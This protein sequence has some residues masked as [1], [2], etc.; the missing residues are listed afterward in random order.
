MPNAEDEL[1]LPELNEERIRQNVE[2][3]RNNKILVR[4]L[5][6]L[7]VWLSFA[8]A[9]LVYNQHDME[10]CQAK[11]FTH[12]TGM[13]APSSTELAKVENPQVYRD[14]FEDCY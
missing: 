4:S 14:L 13:E 9:Y 8:V 2:A 11:L 1:D 10:K 3:I 7:V 6:I 5:W 12:L